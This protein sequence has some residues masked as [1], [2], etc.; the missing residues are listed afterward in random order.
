MLG[1]SDDNTDGI[2]L[3][4][5]LTLLGLFVIIHSLYV[6]LAMQ[7][8]FWL[9]LSKQFTKHVFLLLSKQCKYKFWHASND[10]HLILQI[11]LIL[12]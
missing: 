10:S 4:T 6:P 11:L 8:L 3:A 1:N 9:L 5:L 12:Q 7:L 2:A